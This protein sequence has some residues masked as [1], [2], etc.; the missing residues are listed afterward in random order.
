MAPEALNGFKYTEEID[1][2]FVKLGTA[3]D[4]WALGCILYEILYG[5]TPYKNIL[6]MKDKIVAIISLNS[7][8]VFPASDKVLLK[9]HPSKRPSIAKIIKTFYAT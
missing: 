4:I 8:I 7:N 6:S 5:Y 3:S 9:K 2:L 1:D